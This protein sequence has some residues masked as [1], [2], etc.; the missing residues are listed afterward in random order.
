MCFGDSAEK[1]IEKKDGSKLMMKLQYTALPPINV[2]DYEEKHKKHKVTESEFPSE[3]WS[4]VNLCT[5]PVR[6]TQIHCDL[7]CVKAFHVVVM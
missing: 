6:Y 1:E 4:I 2:D 7:Q 5:D 3:C